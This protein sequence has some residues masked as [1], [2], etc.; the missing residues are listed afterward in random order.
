MKQATLFRLFGG[1][2]AACMA[3]APAFAD[4]IDDA[5]AAGW[6][7]QLGFVPEPSLPALYAGAA[8]F[9]YPSIYEGFGLPPIEAM[10]CGVPVLVA[11]RSCL[12][13]VCANA[14]GHVDPDDMA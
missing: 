2:I 10:A 12:P 5:V 13:E 4:P 1:F 14:A 6:L 9:V 7:K 11:N 3:S 8:L